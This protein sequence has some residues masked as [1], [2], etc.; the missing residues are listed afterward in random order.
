MNPTDNL[1]YDWPLVIVIEDCYVPQ[2]AQLI[3]EVV[4]EQREET[5]AILWALAGMKAR[6]EWSRN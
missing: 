5:H 4:S 3:I 6:E 1:H 2:S